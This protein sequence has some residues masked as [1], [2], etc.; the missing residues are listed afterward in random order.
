MN[1]IQLFAFVILPL[2]LAAGGWPVVLLNE[3][4]NRR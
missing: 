1:G 2:A 4:H 3:R